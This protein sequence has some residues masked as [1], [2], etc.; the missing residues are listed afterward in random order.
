M[1]TGA[2]PS[3]VETVAPIWRSGT[4]TRSMGR[5]TAMRRRSGARP[6]ADPPGRPWTAACWCPELP[7]SSSSPPAPGRRRRGRCRLR[8]PGSGPRPRRSTDASMTAPRVARTP[9]VLR[10]SPPGVGMRTSASP[11]PGRR[12]AAPDGRSTCRPA[13]GARP[14]G[15][16]RAR[17][18][19]AG[20]VGA[21]PSSDP[22]A[23]VRHATEPA[24]S[25]CSASAAASA[26]AWRR[27]ADRAARMIAA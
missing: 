19:P 2:C 17:R 6:R 22:V 26:A 3:I 9:A 21:G 4:A 18:C 20:C 1:V 14:G 27:C 13:A 11:S 5:R 8:G 24:P 23:H 15:A 7:W 16:P 10:T 12:T 25:T